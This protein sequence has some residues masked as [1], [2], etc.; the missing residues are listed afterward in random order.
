MT[1]DYDRDDLAQLLHGKS[2]H[3]GKPWLIDA[4]AAHKLAGEIVDAGFRKIFDGDCGH[5]GIKATDD[6]EAA[7]AW[8]RWANL[9][10]DDSLG[11]IG[12]MKQMLTELGYRKE[13]P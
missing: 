7:E 4:N 13:R 9:A 6:R 5:S 12:A 1:R 8:M 10:M 2:A 3:L 11:A